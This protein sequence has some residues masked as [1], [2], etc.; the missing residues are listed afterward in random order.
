MIV[1]NQFFKVVDLGQGRFIV[2]A[3]FTKDDEETYRDTFVYDPTDKE[4]TTNAVKEAL[5]YYNGPI[6]LTL[7]NPNSRDITSFFE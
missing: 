3:E 1:V 7:E 6:S 2:D 4:E 5:P